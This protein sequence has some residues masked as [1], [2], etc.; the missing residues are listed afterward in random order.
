M[1]YSSVQAYADA[2]LPARLMAGQI[3][4]LLNT[5]LFRSHPIARHLAAACELMSHAAAS[6]T[7]PDFRINKAMM[8]GRTVAVHEEVVLRHPFCNLVHFRKET[9]TKQPRVL[10]VAPLSG[11]FATLLRGTIET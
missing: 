10:L 7:R 5:P 3:Q 11:H 2:G 1:L 9:A 8:R 4:W 6:H